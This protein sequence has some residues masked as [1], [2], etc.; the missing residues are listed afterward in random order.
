MDLEELRNF[1]GKPQL[2]KPWNCTK[3]FQRTNKLR[4]LFNQNYSPRRNRFIHYL[5]P[6]DPNLNSNKRKLRQLIKRVSEN[7]GKIL[8][9]GSGGRSLAPGIINL[10]ANVYEQVDVV[11]DAHQLPF[12][13]KC[14]D[15]IIITA[16]LEHVK[17]PIEVV[18][19]IKQCLRI[20]GMVYAE[21][22]FLQGFHSDPHDYQRYTTLGLKTLFED[23]KEEEVGVCSGPI[24]VLTW[25][26]RKLPTIFFE[27]F[28][29]IK[30]IEFLTGW[31][32]FVF[33][34]LDYFLVR[35]KNS[36]ILASG[37]YYIGIKT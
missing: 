1:P 24:S 28:F 29:I 36:H 32:I 3:V 19:E 16:V 20:G 9:L 7:K 14:F 25:Y 4:L 2:K 8:D 27:N 34:Y 23:F 21:I 11:G 35:A 15:L 37:L 31:A 13:E 30:A 33:K 18:R 6:P 22:P 26:L 5:R 12:C 17:Y 10:D